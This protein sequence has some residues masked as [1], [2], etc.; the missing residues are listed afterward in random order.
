MTTETD[1]ITT[2]DPTR[3]ERTA[4]RVA[5]LRT[6]STAKVERWLLIAGGVLIPLGILLVLLGWLG[7]S[8]TPLLF[9]QVPYLI[10]GGVLGLA[11]V[12]VGGFAYFAYWHTV[13]IRDART[14]HNELISA[15]GRMESLLVA[16]ELRASGGGSFSAP[17]KK[18]GDTKPTGLVSTP[19]GSMFHRPDCAVVAGRE[20]LRPVE[21]DA[22]G[23][24]PCLICDPLATSASN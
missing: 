8:Q 10:S 23:L 17:T 4:S 9:E 1:T 19:N 6:S 20:G 14:Q 11:L 24:R 18:N 22:P 16:G 15:L 2:A 3:N 13:G 7:A 12:F 5:K 21:P